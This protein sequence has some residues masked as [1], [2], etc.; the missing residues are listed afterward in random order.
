MYDSGNVNTFTYGFNSTNFSLQ[1]EDL[2][3][4]HAIVLKKTGIII[5]IASELTHTW[6]S[7]NNIYTVYI[8]HFYIYINNPLYTAKTIFC[9]LLSPV[10]LA[11]YY[12]HFLHLSVNMCTLLTV[13]TY[14]SRSIKYAGKIRN[15]SKFKTLNWAKNKRALLQHS[16][17]YTKYNKPLQMT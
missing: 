15:K 7:I 17:L 14:I 4:N 5:L 12:L 13:A 1:I 16:N 8:L 2:K 11:K 9:T 6:N 3:S 10:A